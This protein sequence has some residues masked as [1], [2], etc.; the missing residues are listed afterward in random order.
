MLE[1]IWML[2][3]KN[4]HKVVKQQRNCVQKATYAEKLKAEFGP[5]PAVHK[6]DKLE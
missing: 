4:L 3:I 5:Y 1:Q 2:P 6:L